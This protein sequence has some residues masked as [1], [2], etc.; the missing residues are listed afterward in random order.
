MRK[1]SLAIMF[2]V[3]LTLLCVNTALACNMAVTPSSFSVQ[4][5]GEV[6]FRLERLQTHKTCTTPLEDTKITITGGELTDPGVWKKGTPDILI[7]KVKFTA[8]GPASVRIE[9][10]CTKEGLMAVEARG[11][12]AAAQSAA[13]AENP[14]NQQ[15]ASG[16]GQQ[17]D[18]ASTPATPDPVPAPASPTTGAA[19]VDAGQPVNGQTFYDNLSSQWFFSPHLQLWYVFFIIGLGIFL[20]RAK[21]LRSPLLF[22]SMIILGFYTGG[23]PEPVGA[24]Y[25]ILIGSKTMVGIGIV[26]LAVPV[27]ISL[28]WGRVFCGWI[29]PLGAVQELIYSQKARLNL[30]FAVDKALKYLK[31]VLLA[32]F[33]LLSWKASRNV[34]SEYEPFKVLFNFNGST[35]GITITVITLLLAIFIERVFCRYL[36]PLGAVL[37]LTSR[38]APYRIKAGKACKSCGACVKGA[39]PVNAISAPGPVSKLPAVDNHECI[40]CLRCE[41]QCKFKAMF[42]QRPLVRKEH[43]ETVKI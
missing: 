1:T 14:A 34:W 25:Y 2:L 7:F 30:P 18:G 43:S 17:K 19:G 20:F 3:L 15:P 23:C 16:K 9:R 22:L 42:L 31:Y 21:K 38:F 36:C 11:T 28:V 33:L 24:V 8:P 27:L 39:C 10:S 40:K 12:V 41:D 4:A 29:C 37:S 5:G 35:V 6:T 13:P 32:V 26:L